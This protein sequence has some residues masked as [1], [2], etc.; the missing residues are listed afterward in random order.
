MILNFKNLKFYSV[1]APFSLRPLPG[2]NI[3]PSDSYFTSW[4]WFG[5]WVLVKKCDEWWFNDSCT[6]KRKMW[7]DDEFWIRYV[8]PFKAIVIFSWFMMHQTPSLTMRNK[9]VWPPT[10]GATPKTTVLPAEC[11][12]KLEATLRQLLVCNTKGDSPLVGPGEI[13]VGHHGKSLR[14]PLWQAVKM[15]VGPSKHLGWKPDFCLFWAVRLHQLIQ[16]L[17]R[18]YGGEMPWVPGQRWI[19]LEHPQKFAGELLL[20]GIALDGLIFP[21]AIGILTGVDGGT[22]TVISISNNICMSCICVLKRISKTKF[23]NNKTES[24]IFNFN[25]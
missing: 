23:R 22:V 19:G 10:P 24:W 3:K 25:F 11:C 5:C 13:L 18:F 15:D 1:Q 14:L 4:Q 17:P 12:K 2:C 7:T 6:P 8:Q 9:W 20:V 16:L 21:V